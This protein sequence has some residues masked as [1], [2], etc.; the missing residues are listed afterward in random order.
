MKAIM[1]HLAISMLFSLS[2]LT[3]HAGEWG[4]A[5]Q[6]HVITPDKWYQAAATCGGKQQSPV[7][8]VDSEAINNNTRVVLHYQREQL[9]YNNNGHAIV[10]DI[11]STI[12]DYT[13]WIELI[14]ENGSHRFDL[15]Q[16]HFHTLS[17]HTFSA[18]ANL[19]P[20]HYDMELHLIHKSSKGQLAVIAVPIQQGQRNNALAELF[21]NLA[22]GQQQGTISRFPDLHGLL[23]EHN[24]VFL[25]NG[26][27]TT[28]PCSEGVQWIVYAA[29]IQLSDTQID[30]YRNL[31]TENGMRYHTN[32]PTQKLNS[33]MTTILQKR[34]VYMGQVE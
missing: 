16:L 19:E 6:H 17:E 2:A 21:Q 33:L 9:P 30:S 23:P 12:A 31:F 27:L 25:Y 7:N 13:P 4:Y 28:P 11:A 29:P 26:S 1:T 14:D 34:K 24:A 5:G 32:R 20:Q 18:T 22:N 10:V 3:V 8:L 15:A